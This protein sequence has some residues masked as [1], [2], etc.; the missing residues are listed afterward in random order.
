MPIYLVPI[1]SPAQANVPPVGAR[2]RWPDDER[3]WVWNGEE[4]VH[5][6]K[7]FDGGDSW[8]DLEDAA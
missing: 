6:R 8:V 5:L 2:V 7:Q 3:V 1:L 4:W